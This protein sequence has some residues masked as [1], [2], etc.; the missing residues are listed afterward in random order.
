LAHASHYRQV[1]E[2]ALKEWELRDPAEWLAEHAREPDNLRAALNW[3][4]SATGDSALGIA[5][6]V[7]AIPLWFHLSATDECR[8]SVQRALSRFESADAYDARARQIVQ[9]YAALGM[10]RAF[11]V[12]LAPQAAAALHKVLDFAQLARL[13]ARVT[14]PRSIVCAAQLSRATGLDVA[15]QIGIDSRPPPHQI[16]RIAPWTVRSSLVSIAR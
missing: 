4:F 3:V 14:S 8:E 2:R 6:T 13:G 9:L 15:L 16:R 10:S 1:F 11:T 12:G 5:L 7:A